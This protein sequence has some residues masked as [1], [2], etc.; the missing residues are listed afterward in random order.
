MPAKR[1]TV[2]DVRRHN[3]STLLSTLFF[4][5]PLSRHDLSRLTGLSAATVSNVTGELAEDGLVVE[6]GL[7]DSDGGRPRVL[8]RVNP[9]HAHVVGVDVGETGIRTELFD[10]ALTRLTTVD[11]ALP[12]GTPDPTEVA[13]HVAASVRAAI[14]QAGVAERGVLG[15]GVGVPGTVEQGRT[16]VVHAQAI[17]WGGVPLEELIRAEGITPPL[18]LENG[19]KTQGQAEM[20]FGAGRGASHVVIALLGSGVGAAVVTEGNVYRGSTSSAGEWGHTTIVYGGRPCRCGSR[21]CLEAYVGAG[22]VLDRY[23]RARGGRAV[24][25]EDERAQ[26]EHLVA[27]AERSAA[28]TRVL[29]ETA[30]YLGAG[31][32]NLVN[33]FNPQRIVLGGWAGLALGAQLL[34]RIEQATAAHA[35]HHPYGQ[36]SIELAR[37]GPDAVAVGAATLPVAALLER[38]ADPR[39]QPSSGADVA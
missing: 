12:A 25:G 36:V 17:G 30:G 32:A 23:R 19:A 29:D 27:A 31:I 37:L 6:A 14:E 21:G 5:G 13:A 26:L 18:F 35:L 20:W 22:G 3:R 9:Q 34:P 15:V 1:T 2:R 4:D 28:A 11:R 33:L 16:A 8:L 38:G 24:P 39:R 7:V 10:L